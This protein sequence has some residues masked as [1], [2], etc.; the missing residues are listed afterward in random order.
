MIQS[1]WRK[2]MPPMAK[3]RS[4]DIPPMPER[5]SV[6]INFQVVGSLLSRPGM[7]LSTNSVCQR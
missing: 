6:Y 4:V 1:D 2:A 7:Q 3:P 5:L